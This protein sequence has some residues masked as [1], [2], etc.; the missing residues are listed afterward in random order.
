MKLDY[1]LS[2]IKQ[3]D[4]FIRHPD[5]YIEYNPRES[6]RWKV[7]YPIRIIVEPINCAIGFEITLNSIVTFLET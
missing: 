4:L 7:S 2:Q 3:L 1:K 6:V 5:E